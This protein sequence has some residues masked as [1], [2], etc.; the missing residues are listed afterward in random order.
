MIPNRPRQKLVA[1]PLVL[2]VAQVRFPA[3]T[4]FDL[5]D[6]AWI[7][8]FLDQIVDQYP[9]QRQERAL[10]IVISDSGVQNELG[11]GQLRFSTPDLGWSVILGPEHLALEARGKAYDTVEDFCRRFGQLTLALAALGVQ[12]QLRFGLRFIN[13]LH[14]PG[15]DEYAY[16]R[17]TLNEQTLG[18]DAASELDATVYSTV[19]ELAAVRADGIF[20]LRRGFFPAGSTVGPLPIPTPEPKHE[21]NGFY[22]IDMDYFKEEFTDFRTDLTDQIMAYDH[23]AWRVFCWIVGEQLYQSF[24]GVRQ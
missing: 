16:W 1:S 15:G 21:S 19:A 20:R 23:F 12:K 5:D 3:L 17:A 2:V 13:E 6:R 7:A 18:F 14:A 11:E 8:P 9:V 10:K 24:L 22:L 4:R